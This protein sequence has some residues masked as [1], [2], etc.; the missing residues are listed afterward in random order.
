[1]HDR[2]VHKSCVRVHE[3]LIKAAAR[4][5]AQHADELPRGLKPTT[6]STYSREWERYLAFVNRHGRDDM[7]GKE[8]PWDALLLWHYLQ[9]RA[10]TCKPSSLRGVLSALAHYGAHR[11]HLLATSRFDDDSVMYRRIR[12]MKNQL[13]IEYRARA[14]TEETELGP[15]RCTPLGC[16]AV[17]F[18]FNSFAVVDR[19]SFGRLA[20]ADRHHLAACAMQHT[21]AMRFGHF[22][23]R[24]YVRDMFARDPDNGSL[25]LVTDWHRYSGRRKYCL[26]FA[27]AP[28]YR[29]RMYTLRDAHGDEVDF[30]SAATILTWH[31]HFLQRDHEQTVFAPRSGVQP[32]RHSRQEWLRAALLAA[33]PVG[34]ARARAMVEDV[35]PH[36]F[37]P[38]LAGDLLREGMLPQA[39]AVECRWADIRNV[40]LYGER[41]PLSAARR[42]SAFRLNARHA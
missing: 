6:L 19:T 14:G 11:G 13:F 23:A 21:C 35:T 15:N 29:A 3:R 18:L 38:G 22:P 20:R 1:M 25:R 36:S 8:G 40:R 9:F 37:R 32:S 24:A 17:S 27:A 12:D 7:P 34:D 10:L 39:I 26:T 28:Q 4:V 31:F 41:L 16:R 33:L 5:S 2:F 30:V 42:S